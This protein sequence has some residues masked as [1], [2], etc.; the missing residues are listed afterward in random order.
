MARPPS[1]LP[2]GDL[3][4]DNAYLARSSYGSYA[5]EEKERVRRRVGAFDWKESKVWH[6]LTAHFGPKLNHEELI[7]IAELIASHAKVKLDRDAKRRKIVLLKWF[8][9]NWL[10]VQP[11]LRVIVLDDA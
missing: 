3:L 2:I 1:V 11:L 8:E 9:E 4:A 5:E 10:V 6:G 7:S